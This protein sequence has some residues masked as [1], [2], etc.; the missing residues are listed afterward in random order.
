MY[1]K[2]LTVQSLFDLVYA[3]VKCCTIPNTKRINRKT[4]NSISKKEK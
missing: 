2:Y 3:T 4:W 1:M